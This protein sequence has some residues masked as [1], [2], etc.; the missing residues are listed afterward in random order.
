MI[1]GKAFHMDEHQSNIAQNRSKYLHDLMFHK[2]VLV[3]RLT[4]VHT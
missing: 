4:N 2:N 1:S 3:D